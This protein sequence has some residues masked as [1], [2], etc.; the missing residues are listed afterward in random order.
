VAA[1][2]VHAYDP[3]GPFLVTLT[4]RDD[5]GGFATTTLVLSNT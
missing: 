4:V 5:D 3:A 2:I 1:S